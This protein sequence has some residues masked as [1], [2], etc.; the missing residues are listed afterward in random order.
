MKLSCLLW[1]VLLHSA[2]LAAQDPVAE[3]TKVGRELFQKKCAGCHGENAKGG[4]APDLTSGNSRHG[5]S[6]EDLIRNITK[7]IPG[8]QMPAF[9]MPAAE[10]HAIVV[11]LHGARDNGADEAVA[12]DPQAGQQLFF[13]SGQC[14]RC[15]MVEGR[16][17]RLGPDLS[18]FGNERKPSELRKAINNPDES[19]RDGFETFEV[20][21]PDGRV[22][23]GAARN[24]D[25]FSIQLMDEKEKL[26]LLLKKDLRRATRIQKSLM[27]RSALNVSQIDDLI[28]FLLKGG[29]DFSTRDSA[30]WTPAADLNVTFARIKNADQEPENWLTYW[31][32]YEG[33]HYSRLDSITPANVKSL[34][35][36]W[37]FQ[38]GG[39]NVEATPIVVDGLM[40]LT[41]PLNNAVALDACTGRAIWQY[42]RRLPDGVHSQCT[43]MTN[44]GLAILGDRL[45]MATLDAHLVALDA[46]TGNVIWDVAVDD[47]RQGF[48]ITHAPL[49]IDGKIIVGITSGECALIGFVD[50]FDAATGKK[51]WRFW[52]IP[53]KG[54]PAR[55]TWAGDSADYG[56]GPTWM[57]G[58][59]DVET[60][61]L[62]WT[63]GNPG[64]DYDGSVRAGD[65]LYTCSVLALD[66]STGRLKWYF[67]F[68]PHDTHDWDAN[69]TPVLINAIFRG[70]PRK[71]LI[72]ANRN[73]FYYVLDRLTGEFLLGR[74]FANQTWAEGLDAKG[75]P[76][77]KPKTDPT[78]QGT[79]V[80][81]DAAGS[82]NWAS[83]S[84]DPHTG[85][86]YV[87]V[88][89]A[90]A[91]YISETKPPKPGEPYTGGGPQVDLKVGTPGFVR[92]L[93]PLTGAIRWSFPLHVGSSAAGVLSTAGGVLFS[94]S[95]D[96]YLIALDARTGRELWHYQTGAQIQSSPIAFRVEGKQMVAISTSSS[97][98]TFALP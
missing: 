86:F 88:R 26:H 98:V 66:P 40:F 11:F 18:H 83:P 52:A 31:G 82:T 14:S 47:Y 51:L 32:D 45:Y 7:G 81:P 19:L 42:K 43:V 46:K 96:G 89:E 36:Q 27:P 93:D 80:C 90:C 41:G 34:R 87:A 9:P 85:L 75:R 35:S 77:V 62:F 17:G 55:S 8:T 1:V 53:Q 29:S 74:S 15:H 68:T 92:A 25:T 10:A 79:Y 39:S 73:G 37:T 16:G 13:G 67:Q 48:S 57:T 23:R 64:P 59:Y 4:R 70:E 54:D 5:D 50:A 61:T 63:T 21:F 33:T 2:S 49:A 69:E 56:G 3:S 78:P 20:E 30:S 12:G 94:A 95:H 60:S 38:Y 76:I 71:L 44:R 58:T 22:Q 91:L 84:Y 65:N 24:N 97:L 6:D 72:Q 28:A